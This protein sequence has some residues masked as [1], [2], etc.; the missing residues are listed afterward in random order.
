MTDTQRAAGGY[1][2]VGPTDADFAC[3]LTPEALGFVATLCRQHRPQLIELL[4]ARK[5]R[6]ARFDAGELPA[7]LADTQ[8]IRDG[9]WRVADIP[10]ALQDRRVEITSPPERKLVINALNAG[11]QGYMADFDDSACPI[12]PVMMRGQVNLRDAVAGSIDYTHPETGERYA[13]GKQTTVLH[14]RPRSLH[15]AEPNLMVDDRPAIAALVDAGLFLFHNA[16]NLVQQGSGPSFYLPKL[17]SHHE[18]AW[19]AAVF[20]TAEASLGLTAGSIKATVIIETLPAAFEMDETL[21]A[22]RDHAVGLSCGRWGSIFSATKALRAQPDRLWP[23]RQQLGMDQQFLD[24]L[25][26][27]LCQTCHRR[28]TLA[29]GGMANWV[30]VHNDEAANAKALGRIRAD[31]QRELDN[32]HDGTWVAH[33]ALVPTAAEVFHALD[34]QNQLQRPL[35]WGVTTDDLLAPPTGEILEADLRNNMGV[36]VQYIE[37]WLGGQGAV[38]LYNLMEDASTAEI[39]RM[40]VW[41]WLNHPAAALADGRSITAELF[42]AVLAEELDIIRAE[43]GDERYASGHFE[44]ATQLMRELCT[45]QICAE[46]FA[47]AAGAM[48]GQTALQRS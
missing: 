41:H 37:A 34:G 11:A 43:V 45:A 7:F 46:F 16:A 13:L 14:V 24:S 40:Q 15:L 27:L 30:P 35:D 10:P 31:K 3:I 8:A 36:F 18:A 28:G 23:G 48:L 26:K 42:E 21:H 1:A 17:E 2:V 25:S 22:L 33:P 5:T 20:S 38:A 29:I 9:D 44:A 6:Q 39:C 12:W 4:A 47:E 32:G 19:W